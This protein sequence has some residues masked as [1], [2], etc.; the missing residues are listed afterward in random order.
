MLPALAIAVFVSVFVCFER[1]PINVEGKTIANFVISHRIERVKALLV[2][3]ELSLKEIAWKLHYS[4]I[5]HLSNQ[6]KKVTGLTP[7]YFKQLRQKQLKPLE[8][9]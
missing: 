3:E 6:F 8:D 1:L 5:A 7:S 4:S 9:L 2:Y